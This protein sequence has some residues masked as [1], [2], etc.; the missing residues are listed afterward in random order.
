MV[1]MCGLGVFE[2]RR[3]IF[4]VGNRGG[5]PT[6]SPPASEIPVLDLDNSTG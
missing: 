2:F 3:A 1:M 4:A 6:S 5:L